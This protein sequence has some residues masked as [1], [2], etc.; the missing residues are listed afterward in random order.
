MPVNPFF[1]SGKTIGRTSEQRVLEDII[2]ES[3]KIYGMDVYY[4]P[5]TLVKED[6]LFGEDVL[7]KFEFA[8]PVEMY[9][10]NIGGYG[11]DGD[12][13]RS[14]GIEIRDN[15]SFV[16]SRARYE[17]AI[18]Q[19]GLGILSR[20]SEGDLIYVPLTHQLFE[21]KFVEHETPFYQLGNLYVWSLD[22]EA[23]VY[24]SEKIETGIGEIDEVVPLFSE[25]ESIY[26]VL[27]E[28]GNIL[29]MENGNPVLLENF[30]LTTIIPG[31][32]NDEIKNEQDAYIDWSETN[33]FGEVRQ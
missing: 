6:I 13:V 12:F 25:D 19:K 22:C 16:V 27:L 15:A 20:P 30:N 7:S 28:N 9:L 29:T 24:S 8:I 11:G 4:V 33:P 14:F 26:R 1:Q 3:I 10:R 21:I 5:R 17:Q 23:F 2:L 32:D 18:Q 31:S